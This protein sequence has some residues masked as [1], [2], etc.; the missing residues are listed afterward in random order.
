M[1]KELIKIEM[2]RENLQQKWGI[3][4]QAQFAKFVSIRKDIV[5]SV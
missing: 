3:T 1:G 2:E 5:R 4:V